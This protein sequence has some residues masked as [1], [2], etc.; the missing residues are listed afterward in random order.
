MKCYSYT[1]F[2]ETVSNK[3]R[4]RI[5][6]LLQYKPLSVN[7]ICKALGEEQSKVSHNLKCLLDCH[8]I[9]VKKEGKKRIYSL[10]KDTIVPLLKIVDKH[11]KKYCC[12]DCRRKR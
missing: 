12:D 3:I 2:F 5:I 7:E 6:E 10:N 1:T 9:E 8:F 4:L 11:V